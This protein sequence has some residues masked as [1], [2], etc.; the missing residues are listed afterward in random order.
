M[1]GR[2][3]EHPSRTFSAR[4]R[5]PVRQA[6]GCTKSR[7]S[8]ERD[9]E[10]KSID[11]ELMDWSGSAGSPVIASHARVQRS[12]LLR[13]VIRP[14]GEINDVPTRVK[15]TAERNADRNNKSLTSD[16]SSR[17]FT[18]DYKNSRDLVGS[19]GSTT[20]KTT[21][22]NKQR[23]PRQINN[24]PHRTG[25]SGKRSRSGHLSRRFMTS[26]S[27]RETLLFFLP[28]THFKRDTS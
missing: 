3:V 14:L 6:G 5:R 23:A 10:D 24:E 21:T 18:T 19:R 25:D 2:E 20:T 28:A 8:R 13:R 12:G 11:H 22:E 27:R 16:S 1:R 9:D 15:S 7:G 4:N 17:L 26:S